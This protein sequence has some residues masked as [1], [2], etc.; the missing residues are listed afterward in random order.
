MDGSFLSDPLEKPMITSCPH[1]GQKVRVSAPGKYRCPSCK[2]IFEHSAEEAQPPATDHDHDHDRGH[3]HEQ[4]DL[5]VEMPGYQ[6][7]DGFGDGE[8]SPEENDLYIDPEEAATA[9]ETCGRPGS[10]QICKSCGRFVCNSCVNRE[11]EEDLCPACVKK[12]ER[13]EAIGSVMPGG[14]FSPAPETFLGRLKGILFSPATFF[15]PPRKKEGLGKALMFSLVAYMIGGAF[16]LA[17]TLSFYRMM[18]AQDP[19][20]NS[21]LGEFGSFSSIMNQPEQLFLGSTIMLPLFWG[22]TLLV[23]SLVIH[24]FLTL[25][26]QPGAKFG[27]TVMVVA[28]SGITKLFQVVPFIGPHIALVWQ[29]VILIV[30]LAHIHRMT[31]GKTTF[32]VLLPLVLLLLLGFLLMMFLLTVAQGLLG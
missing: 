21:F 13:D 26:G 17:Y 2:E 29:V 3:D 25:I 31:A 7:G 12:R 19:F 4:N 6:Q 15:A 5:Y 22:V 23:T 28:Y 30:G 8:D 16:L 10:T 11:F 1:C 14:I 32:A 9:C 24:L 27:G 18:P 20:L